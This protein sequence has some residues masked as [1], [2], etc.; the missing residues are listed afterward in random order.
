MIEK[1]VGELDV[2]SEKQMYFGTA[3]IVFSKQSDVIRFLDIFRTNIFKVVIGFIV[4]KIFRCQVKFDETYFDGHKVFAERAPEPGDVFWENLSVAFIKRFKMT[5]ITYTLTAVILG[6]V[7]II[8]VLITLGKNSLEVAAVKEQEAGNT[9]S[10]QLNMI[11][12]LSILMSILA[13][14]IN[15]AL[16]LV[17]RK[18]S[19]KENHVTYSK[20]HLSVASKLTAAMFINTGLIPLL[21][22]WGTS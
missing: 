7:L 2:R 3:F 9:N 14:F 10:A 13:S 11:R 16:G 17:I 6:F 21:T 20:Y 12:F 5:L 15:A 1:E 4:H 8:N 22:N 19:S 18:F